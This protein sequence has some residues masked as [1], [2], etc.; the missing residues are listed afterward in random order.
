[1]VSEIQ[2]S[3]NHGVGCAESLPCGFPL[4][5]S[6]AGGTLTFSSAGSECGLGGGDVLPEGLALVP[7][8][9]PKSITS[10]RP[11][12]RPLPWHEGS[13]SAR[14]HHTVLDDKPMLCVCIM[15]FF[16]RDLSFHQ[17]TTES[18][19]PDVLFPSRSIL[20][21]CSFRGD[22]AREEPWF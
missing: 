6:S 10:Q 5:A 4:L 16:L 14:T 22:A 12:P 18:C 7:G 8:R 21:V 20:L 3:A 2:G 11:S 9:C 17:E 1:M 13:H 15:F 19:G